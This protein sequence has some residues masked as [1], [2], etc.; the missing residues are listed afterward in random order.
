DLDADKTPVVEL[1]LD[2]RARERLSAEMAPELTIV[3]MESPLLSAFW[4]RPIKMRAGVFLPPSYAKKADARWPTVY[5]IHGYSGILVT[6]FFIK[7][8]L[9]VEMNSGKRPELIYVFLDGSFATGHHEFADSVNNGPWG[10]ALVEEF[11]PFLERRF[12]M[13][14]EPRARFLTGHSSGGWSSLWLQ[15]THP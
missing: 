11:I 4:G 14:A 3:E 13:V 5:D 1:V 6:D 12:R 15:I 7:P 10:R 9:G 2:H 8:G